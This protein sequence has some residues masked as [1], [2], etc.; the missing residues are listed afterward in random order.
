MYKLFKVSFES[1]AAVLSSFLVLFCLSSCQTAGNAMSGSQ[2]IQLL[3][4]VKIAEVKF[5]NADMSDID[6]WITIKVR[7]QNSL[8]KSISVKYKPPSEPP[9]D[10][11]LITLHTNNITA[12]NLIENLEV[13]GIL[14]V[15]IEGGTVWFMHYE[16]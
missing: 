11:P 9:L 7:E 3:K 8:A 1:V 5:V 2:I 12:W 13:Q 16:D 15:R 6:D 10:G 14:K 4:E